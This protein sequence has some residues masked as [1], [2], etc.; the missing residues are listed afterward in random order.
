MG[1]F[2][3]VATG[4]GV[5][6]Y[7]TQR[8]AERAATSFLQALGNGDGQSTC[9]GMTRFAQTELAA[10]Y[11]T[12]TCPQAV[13]KLLQPLSSAERERLAK[14]RA[15]RSSDRGSSVGDMDLGSNPLQ[16][17]HLVLTRVDGKWL[18]SQLS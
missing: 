18:V 1:L 17:T 16:L 5:L 14:T 9:A 4:C 7:M 8:P 15:K 11:R 6:I 12:D 10:R 2:V 13:A 3:G